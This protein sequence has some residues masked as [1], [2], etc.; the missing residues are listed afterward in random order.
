MSVCVGGGGD[1]RY[2]CVCGSR[3]DCGVMVD[4]EWL[5]SLFFSFSHLTTIPSE[6]DHYLRNICVNKICENILILIKLLFICL[7]EKV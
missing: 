7:L 5:M 2:V 3:G 4:K 6:F 1:Q